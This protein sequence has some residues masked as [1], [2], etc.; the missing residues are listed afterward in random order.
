MVKPEFATPADLFAR[1]QDEAARAGLALVRDERGLALSDGELTVRGGFEHMKARIRQ[2]RRGRELLV[3]AA[4]V[5]HPTGNP[6]A[7]DATAGLG[8]DSCLLAAA[9][10]RVLMIERNPVIAALLL[11]AVD[12]ALAD[13]ELAELA[14]RLSI[15]FGDSIE[16]LR[17]CGEHP[18]MVLLDPMFPQRRKSA[19]VKKKLQLLQRLERPCDDERALIDAAF[20]VHPRKVVV[21]RPAKGPHLA[22]AKPDYSIE[23]KAIRFDCYSIQ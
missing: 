15:A 13:P 19:A 14:G 18:D 16:I 20:S 2:D 17:G 6:F 22:G 11:D 1:A 10:F 21:K 4:K 12:R 8:D 3:K 9:G 5:K 7:I 23:G